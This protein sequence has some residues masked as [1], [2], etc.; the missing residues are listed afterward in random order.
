MRSAIFLTVFVSL[1]FVSAHAKGVRAFV[2]L[3]P[4]GSFEASTK[5]IS[6][7]VVTDGKKYAAKKVTVKVKHL[8]TGI[9][10]RDDH[11]HKKLKKGQHSKIILHKAIAQKGAGKGILEIGGIKKK[12]SFTYED[13]GKEVEVKFALNL[14]SFAIG[15]VS[16]MGVGVDDRVEVIATLPVR[17]KK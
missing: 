17:R 5:K 10:L 8:K 15:G 4:A 6:G 16:Y 11:L 14:Q 9:D 2:N 13:R 12:I 3:S 7:T 1:F